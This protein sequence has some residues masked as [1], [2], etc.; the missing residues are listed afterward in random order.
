LN[1]K[2]K[3]Q[4]PEWSY[5]QFSLKTSAVIAASLIISSSSLVEAQQAYDDQGR[6]NPDVFD[7]T[8]I[9][10]GATI[11]TRGIG[12]EGIFYLADWASLRVGLQYLSAIYETTSGGID[13]EFDIVPLSSSI[14]VD[15]FPGRHRIFRITG[16]VFLQDFDV[17]VKGT[18]RRDRRQT[19]SGNAEY[20][21]FAPYLGIGFGNPVRP[22]NVLS[23][24]LDIGVVFQDYS[25][26][27]DRI[28]G[29]SAAQEAAVRKDVED[30]LDLFKIYP[31][32]KLGVAYHF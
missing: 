12:G 17:N 21:T 13:Y 29:L 3:N 31:I 1:S 27:Y 2:V 9:A 11:G 19:F 10:L 6:P 20:D 8:G 30:V 24:Y 15:V 7:W 16:G 4:K 25:L 14:L 5:M 26:T 28:G 18:L 23:T 32:I 22:D